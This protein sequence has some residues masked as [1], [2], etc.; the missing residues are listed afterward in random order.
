MYRLLET[1]RRWGHAILNASAFFRCGALAENLYSF[2]RN[3]AEISDSILT[4]FGS[5]VVSNTI[6]TLKFLTKETK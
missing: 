4:S 1:C 5:I 3:F 2:D 6:V